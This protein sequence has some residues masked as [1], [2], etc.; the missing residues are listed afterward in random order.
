MTTPSPFLRTYV[1][2]RQVTEPREGPQYPLDFGLELVNMS[3][4]QE[5]GR[6]DYWARVAGPVQRPQGSEG[7]K[8]GSGHQ[9]LVPSWSPGQVQLEVQKKWRQ[10]HLRELPLRPVA[11]SNSFSIGTSSLTHGTKA[12][13]SESSRGTWRTSVI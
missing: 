10:W 1:V 8:Q 5:V 2:R 9:L 11:L 12:S 3:G 13:P 6:H 4:L 7:T